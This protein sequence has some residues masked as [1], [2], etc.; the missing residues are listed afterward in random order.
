MRQF[1]VS[2]IIPT[3]NRPVF[4]AE[5]VK[6]ILNQTCRALEIIIIDNGSGPEQ[7]SKLSTIGTLDDSIILVHLQSNKGP[8]YARNL[9]ISISKG[10]WI[11]FLDD[12]DILSPD[13]IEACF[14]SLEFETNAEMVI[15]RAVSFKSGCSISYPRDAI[16]AIN[17]K[18]CKKDPI[19]TLLINHIAIDSCLVKRKAIGSLRFREDIWHGEDT[20]FWFSLLEKIKTLATTNIA[21]VGIR[22]H[23]NQTT[24]MNSSLKLDGSPSF[25]KAECFRAILD[26]MEVKNPWNEFMLKIIFK[27]IVD[28]TWYSL[29]VI[30]TLMS[31]PLYGIRMT[32][33]LLRKRLYRYGIM[34]T[35]IFRKNIRD[36][37]W[38]QSQ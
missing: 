23:Q 28:N 1:N 2:V 11:L 5:A 24:M 34:P 15:G 4:L 22:Q 6:S 20:L 25:S 10:D 27:R 9:G 12:D 30:A 13:F 3:F 26:S 33:L 18:T 8:G 19:T 21:F 16:G 17:L 32:A 31:N 7:W 35:K 36:F 14:A 38:L 29:P 37:E